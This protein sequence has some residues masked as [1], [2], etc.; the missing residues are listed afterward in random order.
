MTGAGLLVGGG[1]KSCTKDVQTAQMT[2]QAGA[3][4]LIDT[5][6]FDDSDLSDFAVVNAIASFLIQQ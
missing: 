2:S 3:I 5:P 4:T 6:G 1:L